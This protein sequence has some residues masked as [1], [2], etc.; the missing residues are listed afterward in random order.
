MI[1]IADAIEALR[2][3]DT[4]F[5]KQCKIVNYQASGPGGQKR[6]RK[7]SA[8][9]LTHIQ[10]NI[11]VTAS[12]FRETHRNLSIAVSKLRLEIALMAKNPDSDDSR[13]SVEAIIFQNDINEKKIDFP[14]SVLKAF[15]FFR[16]NSGSVRE[17]A[18][19]LFISSPKLIKFFKKN[20]QVWQKTQEI[21][22]EFGHTP[23]N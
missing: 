16:Q 11:A 9:R 3:P 6:N 19:N 7:L 14:F 5:I 20:R 2:R 4:I 10:S 21:R 1:N 22:K 8:V 18:E 12:E 23:L 17:T 13:K 15:V